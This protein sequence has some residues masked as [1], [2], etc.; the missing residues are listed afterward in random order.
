M[1]IKYVFISKIKGIIKCPIKSNIIDN[2]FNYWV[3]NKISI[4]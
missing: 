4:K 3:K 1:E 2:D